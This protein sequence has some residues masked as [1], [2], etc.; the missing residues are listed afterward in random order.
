MAAA[1]AAC[2]LA[3]AQAGPPFLSN[4]PGTPGNTNWEINVA[5]MQTVTRSADSYQTPQIDINFGVGSNLQLTFE[6]PYIIQSNNGEAL[7]GG[8]SNPLTGLKWRF[9]D[10]GDHGWQVS[11]FPQI[12]ARASVAAQRRGL[13][14]PGPR[15]LLPLEIS[16]AL[17]TVHCDV[18]V[19]EYVPVHG[20]HERIFGFVIGHNVTTQL[21]LDAEIYDDR[22]SDHSVR[23]TV[24]DF[25]GRYPLHRGVIALFMMG[26]SLTGISS[27]QPE[28]FGYLG[29]QVL[30][31]DYGR[32]LND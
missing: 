13:S 24:L 11:T 10:Q 7:R 32:R 12:E 9:L 17:G 5:S 31:A 27:G 26:R 20:P 3:H 6:V 28:F 16:R 1:F 25:G 19:G 14:Q 30:L 22:A 21:E 18:E 15:V 29:V 2:S 4:D 8:W 23:S